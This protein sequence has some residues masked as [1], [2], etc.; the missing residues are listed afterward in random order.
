MQAPSEAFFLAQIVRRHS[1][2]WVKHKYFEA[3]CDRHES[4][5]GHRAKLISRM[6]LRVVG[7]GELEI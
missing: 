6:D 4:R 3:I 2:F 5:R 1:R 7:E